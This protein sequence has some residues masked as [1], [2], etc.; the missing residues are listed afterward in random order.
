[1]QTEETEE[2]EETVPVDAGTW[3]DGNDGTWGDGTVWGE[4]GPL[5]EGQG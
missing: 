3:G 2:T 5:E 4:S 1:M